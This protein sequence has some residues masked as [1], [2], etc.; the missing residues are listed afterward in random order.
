MQIL[1]ESFY[2]TTEFI[3][4]NQVAN[5]L[6]SENHTI[7]KLLVRFYKFSNE[8]LLVERDDINNNPLVKPISDQVTAYCLNNLAVS[9]NFSA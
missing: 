7:Y 5:L 3:S 1:G 9:A 4:Q 2:T 6:N 8:L